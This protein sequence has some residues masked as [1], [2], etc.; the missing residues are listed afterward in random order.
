MSKSIKHV[1]TKSHLSRIEHQRRERK[2]VRDMKA[3]PL[4]NL[5]P[6]SPR[7]RFIAAQPF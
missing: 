6:I 4:F 5:T 1:R 3:D 2:R 7:N